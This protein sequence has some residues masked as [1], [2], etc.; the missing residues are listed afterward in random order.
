[1]ESRFGT[2]TLVTAGLI[3]NRNELA[4]ELIEQGAT[5]SEIFDGRIN[6]TELVAKLIAQG[7]DVASG[8]QGVFDRI[9]GSVSLL[10]MTREGI[11][12]ACDHTGRLPLAIA[13]RDDVVAA[14]SET[15]AFPNLGLR[16]TKDLR[17]G[18]T[19]FFDASGP[20]EASPGRGA[21]KTCAFLWIYT[22]YPASSY[23]G[24]SVE[25]VRERCGQALAR[26]DTIEADLVSGVPDSGTGHAI[27]Y[28][29][30]SGLPFRRPLRGT[31]PAM[32]AATRRPPR[33]S[34]TTSPR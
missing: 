18:E 4:R 25:T 32:A 12:A 34:A 9:E 27:G 24:A 33:R 11:Y 6:Q 19:V 14:A 3:T 16:V 30:A 23:E 2:F 21:K 10:F 29:M 31:P 7:A 1:M 13:E 20:R 5:F 28:A 15:C 22:G 26:K 8:I 17:A